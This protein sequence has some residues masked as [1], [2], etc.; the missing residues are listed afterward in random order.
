MNQKHAVY[1]MAI[2]VANVAIWNACT[3]GEVQQVVAAVA[4]VADPLLRAIGFC[5]THPEVKDDVAKAVEL[6]KSGDRLGATMRVALIVE[7]LRAGGVPIPSNVDVDVVRTMAA[8]ESIQQGL[9][10]LSCRNPDGSPKEGCD[11]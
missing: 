7:E 8:V 1:A 4:P 5:Q 6:Y 3:P 2:V 11:K 10:A 9:R